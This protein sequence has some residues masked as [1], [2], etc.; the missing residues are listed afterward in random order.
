MSKGRKALPD[1]V[2]K[3]RGTGQPCRLSGAT[4]HVDKISDIKKISSTAQ[5]KLLPTKRARNIFKQKA[6]QLI[7]LGILTELDIEHL[8]VYANSLDILF[9]C[10]DGMREPAIAKYNK[11]GYLIGYVPHPEIAM[12]KQMV[13]HVN[14]IGSEFGFTPISR[15]KINQPSAEDENPFLNLNNL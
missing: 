10:M 12:Y 7:G 13:E 8:A 9:G 15:Q 4:D 11:S 1:A 5:L 6:N 2:K 3:L 14:R